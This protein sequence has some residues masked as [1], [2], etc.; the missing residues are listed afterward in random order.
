MAVAEPATTSPATNS[1]TPVY[2][3][4]TGPRR[5]LQVPPA[6]IPARP[7]AIGPANA[8]AYSSRPPSAR[9]TTGIAVVTASASNAASPTRATIPIVT[10][11]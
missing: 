4:R 3:G 11:R 8:M 9:T 5:S 10:T 6:T 2:S 7:E 1:A